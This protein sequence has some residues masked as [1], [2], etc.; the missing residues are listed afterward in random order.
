MVW[1]IIQ[2]MVEA[3]KDMLYLLPSVQASK[4]RAAVAKLILQ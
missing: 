3:L 4:L 1:G 2:T